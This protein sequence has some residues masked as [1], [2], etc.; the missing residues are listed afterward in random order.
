[1]GMDSNCGKLRTLVAVFDV[2]VSKVASLCGV[3]RPYVARIL[4]VKDDFSGSPQFWSSLERNL[5]KVI[6]ARR[7]QV[8]EVAATSAEQVE[9]L[10]LIA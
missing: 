8:F 9:A 4:R 3:S 1:M 5:G 6:E 7:A 10:K 2:S